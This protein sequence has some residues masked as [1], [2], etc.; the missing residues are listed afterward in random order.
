MVDNRLILD[1]SDVVYI[2]PGASSGF[3][4]FKV[5]P[6]WGGRGGVRS[7]DDYMQVDHLHLSGLP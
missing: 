2:V 5:D 3:E 6:V 1:Y 7:R 4:G